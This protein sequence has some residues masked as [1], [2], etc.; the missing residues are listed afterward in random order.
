MTSIFNRDGG[1]ESFVR[2][3]PVSSVIVLLNTVMLLV[4][5]VTG[6][7]STFNLIEL[8]GLTVSGIDAKEYY[9]FLM[10][11]FLHG[12]VLHFLSNMI[13]GVIVLSSGLERLIG[14]K[15]FFII[16]FSSLIA[17]S[18]GVYLIGSLLNT[19]SVTIGA[20]GAIFGVL[21]ALLFMTINRKEMILE[22]DLQ[23]IKMLVIIQVVFT[24][25][26]SGTSISGHISGIIFG[27]LV[28]FLFFK[29]HRNDY[30]K[31]TDTY[32][33]TIH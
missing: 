16:Y 29:T 6:G 3:S 19:N 20:S 15:K 12:S 17:S 9:R 14:S 8:G 31:D 4:T 22:R 27:Y 21:G 11:G 18:F 10:A 23:S 28:S 2:T 24:F 25:I 13:I 26:N 33:F 5:L 1:F 32:D 7:F 30:D